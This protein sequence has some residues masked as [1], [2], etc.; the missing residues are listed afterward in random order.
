MT[1]NKTFPKRYNFQFFLF[2]LNAF[3][4]KSFHFEQN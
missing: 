4:Q 2:V 3:Y 1:K